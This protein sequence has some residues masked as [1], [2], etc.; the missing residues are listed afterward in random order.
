MGTGVSNNQ[1]QKGHTE[2]NEKEGGGEAIEYKRP[3]FL[4]HK[5]FS[6]PLLRILFC[7]LRTS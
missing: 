3:K 2:N 6:S 1:K 4:F 7:S 5:S